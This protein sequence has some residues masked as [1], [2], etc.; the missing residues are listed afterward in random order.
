MVASS[1]RAF[2]LRHTQL[3]PVPGLE[4]IRLHLGNEV[5]PLWNAVQVETDDPDAAIPY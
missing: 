1:P 2:V 5:L 3:R 4:E